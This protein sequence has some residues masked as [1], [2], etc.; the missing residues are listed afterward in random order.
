MNK[1]FLIGNS[2]P[3]NLIRRKVAIIPETM[4]HFQEKL[5]SGGGESFWGHTNTLAAAKALCGYDFTP[6]EHRPALTLDAD[7]YPALFGKS[8]KECWVM[9]PEYLSGYRP[10]LGEE[11]GVDKIL[12]WQILKIIWE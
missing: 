7:G 4:E 12:S 10:A 2:F 1:E 9:A 8:Y 6:Q 3:I 11:V 5:A